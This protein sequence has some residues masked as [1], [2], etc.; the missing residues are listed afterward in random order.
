MTARP[1]PFRPSAGIDAIRQRMRDQNLT[2]IIVNR[3]D[4]ETPRRRARR[5]H[6]LRE[7]MTGS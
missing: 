4:G 7:G 5:G 1:S 6:R 2:R 3:S